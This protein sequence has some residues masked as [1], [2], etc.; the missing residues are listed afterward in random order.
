MPSAI[1]IEGDPAAQLRQLARDLRATGNV[2]LRRELNKSLTVAA[3]P[4]I[5]AAKASAAGELPKGG[6]RGV[7]SF[8]RKTGAAQKRL[9]K[10]GFANRG[11]TSSRVESLSS[12]VVNAKFKVKV[13]AG[14]NPGVVLTAAGSN[15]RKID[16]KQLDSGVVRHPLFGNRKHWYPQQVTPGW[17]SR[18][19][20]AGVPAVTVAVKAAVD[21]AV[22]S[23]YDMF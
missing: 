3:Q 10:K 15:G 7:R 23:F 18:P 14:H 17:W 8:N 11:G 1:R 6:G 19:M 9:K 13:K 2:A 16:L 21:K 22:A 5:E 12:R 4:L 20:E